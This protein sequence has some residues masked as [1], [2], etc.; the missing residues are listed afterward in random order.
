MVIGV[1]IGVGSWR[2][3]VSRS[4]GTG[5]SMIGGSL[6]TAGAI[7]DGL[8]ELREMGRI[9]R[10][11]DGINPGLTSPTGPLGELG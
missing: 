11:P 7:G 5:W 3:E 4:V 2:L 8:D 10:L 6:L 9:T 1:M